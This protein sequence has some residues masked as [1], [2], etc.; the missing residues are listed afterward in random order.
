MKK[1]LGDAK[2]VRNL[3]KARK[4]HIDYYQREYEWET[5][6]VAELVQDLTGKFLEDYEDGHERQE[7]VRYGHY[8][9]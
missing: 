8:F 4:Y 5:K 9:L 6:Q 3:L 1:I 7:I 2:S